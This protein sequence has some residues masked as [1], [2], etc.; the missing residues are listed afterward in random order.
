MGSFKKTIKSFIKSPFDFAKSAAKGD[1]GGMAD[2]LARAGILDV[3]KTLET[4][5]PQVNLSEADKPEQQIVN[6]KE[7]TRNQ[8]RALFMTAGDELGDPVLSVVRKK[9]GNL[10]GN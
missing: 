9:R 8:R 4:L 1:I 10:L 3:K 7:E 2:A 6:A 5:K